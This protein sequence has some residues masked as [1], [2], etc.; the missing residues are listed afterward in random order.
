MMHILNR[1]LRMIT[2][3][4][5]KRRYITRLFLYVSAILIL[6]VVG[7]KEKPKK[8]E[9][10]DS[11]MYVLDQR[12]KHPK[13]PNITRRRAMLA[14]SRWENGIVDPQPFLV[15]AIL[16]K[17]EGFDEIYLTLT[18]LDEDQDVIGFAIKEEQIGADSVFKTLYERYPVF[19]FCLPFITCDVHLVPIQIRTKQ[20]QKD[21]GLWRKYLDLDYEELYKNYTKE[22]ARS[23]DTAYPE[24]FWEETL[25]PVW[26]SIPEP[27]KVDVW[28]WVYDKTGNKSEP[29][30]LLNFIDI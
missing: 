16:V 23:D 27:N 14:K 3:F 4:T 8:L 22:R 28:I 5:L 29:V 21:E 9:V 18:I 17:F 19:I 26:L 13:S 20:Q 7:C 10:F 1:R 6:I 30:R 25:P 24:V 2:F 12:M 15:E 11:V